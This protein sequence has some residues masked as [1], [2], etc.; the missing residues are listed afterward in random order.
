MQRQRWLIRVLDGLIV[1]LVAWLLA[2]A[3]YV[4]LGRQFV[5]A[6]ADYR[7]E[8]LEWAREK[9]GRAITLDSLRGEMQGSQ[10]VL[11]MRGLRVH[12]QS[13]PAS[14]TL[15]ALDHVTARIDLWA[16][17][18]QRKLVMDAL[19]IE[20]L[21]LELVEDA[22]GRW[23]LHGLG[24]RL[25]SVFDFD[26]SLDMLLEQRRITLLD[27]SIRISPHE[28]PPWV[29]QNGEI[30]LLNGAG[31]HRLDGR[32]RLPEGQQVSWQI[33]AL[34]EGERW[35]DMSLG[36]YLDMPPIDWVQ[37]LPASWLELARLDEV[38]AGGQFWGEWQA[39][40]LQSLRGR[41][42]APLVRL[43]PAQQTSDIRDLGAEFALRLGERQQL[44]VQGLGFRLGDQLWL[45][46]RLYATRETTTDQ[47]QLQADRLSLDLMA[48]MVPANLLPEKP[49]AAL[50][51]LA[52]QGTLREV[53][54]EGTGSPRDWRSIRWRAL[55]DDVGVQAWQGAPAIQGI[56]GSVIGS[57]SQ[58][59][60]RVAS[61]DWGMHLPKLFPQAWSY[62]RLTGQMDWQWSKPEGL[63]LNAPGIRVQGEEGIAA[64]SLQL[65]LPLNGM[66]PTM[67]LKV[68]LQDTQA[69]FSE[70]Y[71]PTLAP[72]FTPKLAEWI[73]QAEIAGSM[74]LV[75]FGFQ[76]SLM[77]DAPPEERQLSLYAR[78]EDG[79][80]A[81][82]P[83]W[84]RLQEVNGTLRMDNQLVQI[85]EA[86]AQVWQTALTGVR[87]TAGRAQPA[88][89]LAL[90]LT[91]DFAGPLHDGLRL[92]QETPLA[93]AIDN[94]M[95]GWDGEGTV[96]GQFTLALPL[97]QGGV[98][99]VDAEWRVDRSTLSIPLLQTTLRDLRGQFSYSTS[100]GLQADGLSGLFLG[101][102]VSGTL[103]SQ[104]GRQEL[105]V[106]GRH[107]NEALQGWSLLAGLPKGL[108]AGET[109][110]EARGV[111]EAGSPSLQIDSDLV[112]VAIDLPG[113]LAKA[114]DQ[115]LPSRLAIAREG[116]RQTWRFNLGA[117]LQ[118]VV[119]T[120]G[121][122][123]RG[124]VRYRSGA[125]V[126]GTGPGLNL[127]ARFEQ[128]DFPLWQQWFEQHRDTLPVEALAPVSSGSSRRAS[129]R[130]DHVR[131]LD[132]RAAQFSGFGQTLNDVA[133][134]GIRDEGGWLFDVDQA[135]IRG[136]IIV[137]D[138]QAQPIAINMQRL[139]IS[140]KDQAPRVDALAS[141]LVPEDPL[142]GADPREFP[143][144]DVNIDTLFWGADP[145]GKVRF[146]MRPNE[147]GSR[148]V[149]LEV[150]LR[151][152]RLD[153]DLDWYAAGPSSR[154]RGN[155]DTEN[156]GQVL[157][158]WGY[159]P[160]VTSRRFTTAADLVW[161]GS[162]IF[163]ALGRS[164]GTLQLDARNGTLQSG[165]GSA[166][167]LR[168]FGLLNFNA[169]TRRLR[170]DFSDL[171]GRGT[172][173][174]TLS[175]DLALTDGVMRTRSPLVMDGPGAKIQLDGQLDLPAGSI[176]MGMLVTLPVTNNLPLAAIIAG[177][178]YIGGVLFLA[179]KI[180]GDRVAR[181]A[182]VKYRVSGDWQQPTV[183]FDRAFDNEAALEE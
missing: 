14:P 157:Q 106:S 124:D 74:P 61:G 144:V 168:V 105:T 76:G 31:W 179:D 140:S 176:D 71:L 137:P 182:S 117:D 175:G 63:R 45:N 102:P 181:F 7:V 39:Q 163:F 152:L 51:A 44:R 38:I 23:R 57:P 84:P 116:E 73:H 139:A 17:L 89:P 43:E 19:Q 108:V 119:Q 70:R 47:W 33:S 164:S 79:S 56:S 82:R 161:S 128:V 42:D 3:A 52:P 112:G 21:A 75:I 97:E 37:H 65:H 2:T 22:G 100:R 103:T 101:R 133:I 154:F 153:G 60:L 118:A 30:T 32:V 86:S 28:R 5:P 165:E 78:L 4:S 104:R 91:S 142:L 25:T 183:E 81:F 35:Q 99:V 92:M 166:D 135:R 132:L 77:R 173:Y 167:A 34:Q 151:G 174:D 134:S 48:Q 136:Q 58:G 26:K 96:E 66:A 114:T 27:T 64:T 36:F 95:Q 67:V 147:L 159:T 12:E 94:N 62:G 180:L 115:A 149:G 171:F 69:G 143:P 162:P 130:I 80:L 160:T 177:A 148:I 85:D 138:L 110:W 145:V 98:P 6:I 18:W 59:E 46:S 88:D 178:P 8:L 146:Q 125:P 158:A 40:Q 93:A 129:A 109:S 55:L 121:S 150:D 123:L 155:L 50:A 172:S 107:S 156:I 111:I 87:V 16:S 1:A 29:F 131:T 20:G 53:R 10:P 15:L 169:L 126:L 24:E 54:L 113:A 90:R 9:T 11:E 122:A 49:A 72:A 41:L 127:A 141:P 83:G 13:D 170:L 68:S 120:G